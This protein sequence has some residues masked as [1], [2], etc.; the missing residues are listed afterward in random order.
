MGRKKAKI[1]FTEK[2]Y[3]FRFS[4]MSSMVTTKAMNGYAT[5]LSM[6]DVDPTFLCTVVF[7]TI[8]S[9]R[10]FSYSCVRYS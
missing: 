4:E 3:R 2:T 7:D 9:Y 1:V 5:Y 8:R 10:I 6:Y